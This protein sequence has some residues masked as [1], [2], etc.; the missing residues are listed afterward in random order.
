MALK[1]RIKVKTTRKRKPPQRLRKE[2]KRE[3]QNMFRRVGMKGVNN[4]RSEIKKRDL[5]DTGAM[6]NSVNYKMTPQGV[7]FE[8]ASPAPYLN[9]GIKKHQM[10]YLMKAKRPIPVDVSNAIFRWASPRSMANGKWIHP[11]FRRGKGFMTD[12]VKRTRKELTKDLKTIANK[13]FS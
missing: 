7:R 8:V 1:M 12:G 4:I 6:Y 3:M 11:G 5:I 9:Q 2:Y 10:K 13:V